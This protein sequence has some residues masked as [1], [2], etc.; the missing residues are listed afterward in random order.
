MKFESCAFGIKF[1][2]TTNCIR[3]L[4]LLIKDYLLG[5]DYLQKSIDALQAINES[6]KNK[7]E[8]DML[9]SHQHSIRETSANL[10]K[11]IFHLQNIYEMWKNK[12]PN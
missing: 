5:V 3:S 7:T 10:Y 1:D 8:N 2:G 4:K 9:E 11:S 12:H 6:V